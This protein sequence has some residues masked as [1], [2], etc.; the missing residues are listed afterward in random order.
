[1]GEEVAR[2][3]GARLAAALR[4]DTDVALSPGWVVSAETVSSGPHATPPLAATAKTTLRLKRGIVLAGDIGSDLEALGGGMP[5]SVPTRKG[6]A[7][8]IFPNRM[9]LRF[10]LQPGQYL[11]GQV[12]HIN[13]EQS[14]TNLHIPLK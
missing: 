1:M 4:G 6:A 7:Q 8:F 13:L 9:V 5:H 11:D 10:D 2:A 3:V 12:P 14:G